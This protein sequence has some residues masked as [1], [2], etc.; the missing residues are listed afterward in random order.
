MTAA[1]IALGERLRTGL[2]EVA[3]RNGF[4]LRQTGPA[5]MPLIMFDDDD[6]HAKGY[7]WNSAMIKRGVYFHPWHNM[8]ICAALTEHDVG[9]TLLATDAAL[10]A[11]KKRR[12]TLQPHPVVKQLFGQH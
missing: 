1:A 10:E 4:G 9:E 12:G 8:F 11:L 3:D 5:Q 7:L 2:N 6:S